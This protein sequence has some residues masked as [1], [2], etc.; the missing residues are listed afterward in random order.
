ME[1][2]YE[3]NPRDL[4]GWRLRLLDDDGEEAGG[5]VFEQDDYAGA[6][7]EGEAWIST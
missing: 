2:A 6:L 7:E 1:R 4:G 3:I 5:G